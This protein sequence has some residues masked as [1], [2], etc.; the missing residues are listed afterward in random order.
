[1][2]PGGERPRPGGAVRGR[3]R[4]PERTRARWERMTT[5]KG[6]DGRPRGGGP[7]ARTGGRRRNPRP[8]VTNPRPRALSWCTAARSGTPPFDGAPC[9]TNLGRG[10]S[11]E[12]PDAPAGGGG[13][14]GVGLRERTRRRAGAVRDGVGRATAGI[15]A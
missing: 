8:P 3:M 5:G 11:D 6:A 14:D 12:E 15:R 7:R 10:F 9:E 4:G 2:R 1:P 13:G